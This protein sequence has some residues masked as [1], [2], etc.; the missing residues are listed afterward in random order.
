MGPALHHHGLLPDG[1]LIGIGAGFGMTVG[2]VAFGVA[3]VAPGF[4]TTEPTSPASPPTS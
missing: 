3:G 2:L 1:A 4:A